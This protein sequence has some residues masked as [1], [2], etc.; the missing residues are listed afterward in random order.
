MTRTNQWRI[1]KY[2]SEME[3]EQSV[4]VVEERERGWKVSMGRSEG[5]DQTGGGVAGQRAY[6]HTS[7]SLLTKHPTVV[8]EGKKGLF[9]LM[10]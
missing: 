4:L 6:R 2:H 3:V 10:V 5:V 1:L 9:W 8:T 7:F